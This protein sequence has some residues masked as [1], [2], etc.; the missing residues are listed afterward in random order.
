MFSLPSDRKT[1]SFLGVP[2]LP[3]R[4]P[5]LFRN[6]YTDDPLEDIV[7]EFAWKNIKCFGSFTLVNGK[8]LIKNG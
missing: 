6:W 8:R 7:E 4:L 2:L 3:Y 5:I 1:T